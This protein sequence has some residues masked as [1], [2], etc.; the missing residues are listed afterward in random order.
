MRCITSANI[1]CGGHA[2]NLQS[3]QTSIRFARQMGV[4]IGAHPGIASQFG[5]GSVDISERDLELLLLHQVGAFE[6]VVRSEHARLHHI[7]L[8]GSLYHAV[9]QNPKLARAYLR[10]VRHFWPRVVIFARAGGLVEKLA[11]KMNV[12]VWPEAFVDRAYVGD[13]SLVP[14]N[15]P[16]ALLTDVERIL[17][18]IERW[19][20]TGTFQT[21]ENQT[22]SINAKTFCLH[23]DTP[24]AIIIARSIVKFVV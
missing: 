24:R 16:A 5:R 10:T 11:S 6:K 9:D 1:A 13:G 14:R 19:Q 22:L 17:E 23:S 21:V 12:I 3:M 7:K 8:H 4:R 18:R 2:G 20:R 15:H